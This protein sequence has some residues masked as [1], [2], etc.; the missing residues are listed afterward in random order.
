MKRNALLAMGVLMSV[1]IGDGFGQSSKSKVAIPPID[2]SAPAK[3][4]TATFAL[5]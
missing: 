1:T 3:I 5:G 4:E 2:Q